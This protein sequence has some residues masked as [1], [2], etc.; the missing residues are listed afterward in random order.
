MQKRI[1]LY[2]VALYAVALTFGTVAA[3]NHLNASKGVGGTRPFLVCEGGSGVKGFMPYGVEGGTHPFGIG[4]DGTHPF[5]S[6]P[7]EQ[8]I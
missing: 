1:V 6:A 8:T 5:V 4:A 2:A 7:T 3:M